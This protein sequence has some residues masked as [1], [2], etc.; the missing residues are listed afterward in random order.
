MSDKDHTPRDIHLLT[1]DALLADLIAGFDISLG[2]GT[3]LRLN[4]DDARAMLDWYRRNQSRWAG[5]AH[6]A[7]VRLVIVFVHPGRNP[8]VELCG[9]QGA[10]L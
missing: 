5:N 8:R 7:F 3:L 10:G 4:S 1:T 2:E 9:G 6:G